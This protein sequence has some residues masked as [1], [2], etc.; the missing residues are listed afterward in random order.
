MK[1]AVYDHKG[2]NGVL[3]KWGEQ[4]ADAN[5]DVEVIR[6]EDQK[7][8]VDA[9]LKSDRPVLMVHLEPAHWKSL[10]DGVR[11]DVTVFRFSTVGFLPTAPA[12]KFSNGF[13]VNP[14]TE[15]GKGEA[16][17][18]GLLP[19]FFAAISGNEVLKVLH[20]E[21]VSPA[22]RPYISFHQP[23]L[24]RALHIYLQARLARWAGDPTHPNCVEAKKL[25]GLDDSVPSFNQKIDWQSLLRSILSGA[26]PQAELPSPDTLR[27]N[28]LNC[29]RREIGEEEDSGK[30]PVKEIGD[31]LQV[32]LSPGADE[33]SIFSPAK[34]AWN[35]LSI[36]LRLRREEVS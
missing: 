36:V 32:A 4:S 17:N 25:L 23:H 7:S 18:A 31:F 26:P 15:N 22:L 16:Y 20:G 11:K 19:G 9:L 35:Q 1:A 30:S 29:L 28:A 27:D 2:K 6:D 21:K 24:A 13:H 33:A 34:E 10:M 5:T 12:G 3:R 8:A 14:R